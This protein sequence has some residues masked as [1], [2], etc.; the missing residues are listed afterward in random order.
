MT[1][2]KQPLRHF[3]Q[4]TKG[5]KLTQ[6]F[7][8]LLRIKV[9]IHEYNLISMLKEKCYY[10]RNYLSFYFI[11]LKCFI[12]RV[13][14]CEVGCYIHVDLFIVICPTSRIIT[15]TPSVPYKLIHLLFGTKNKEKSIIMCYI[16]CGVKLKYK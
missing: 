15:Y 2:D 9:V 1:T 4:E 12:G 7:K 8:R 14:K 10:Y 6:T 5:F 3:K 11:E 13:G 16:S